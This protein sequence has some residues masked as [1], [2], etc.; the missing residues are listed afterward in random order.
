MLS[1]WHP[2]LS[3]RCKALSL[4]QPIHSISVV[5][6]IGKAWAGTQYNIVAEDA[7]LEGTT[8]TF[9]P[10]SREKTNTRV[11]KIAQ[12]TAEMLGAQ[13]DVFFDAYSSPLINDETAARE[14]QNVARGIFGEDGVITN[15]PKSLG[16][17]DFA[18][19][20]A[21]AKG[22]FVQVGTQSSKP[23]TECAHHNGHFDVDENGLVLSCSLY[24]KYALWVLAQD[25]L[26]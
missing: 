13:A 12:D 6:G 23:G 26:A 9:T 10:E 22:C 1:T 21:H 19:Y 11:S 5:V 7:V 18:D 20:L 17:E 3:S 16:A 2:R 14:I 8:R 24:V 15:Q 4:A 25:V